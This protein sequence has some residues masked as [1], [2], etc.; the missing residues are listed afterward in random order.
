MDSWFFI[1]FI[2][3]ELIQQDKSELCNHIL[4]FF[5]W[6]LLVEPG[7]STVIF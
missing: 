2:Y 4:S 5:E 6:C 7:T 1:R 3:R